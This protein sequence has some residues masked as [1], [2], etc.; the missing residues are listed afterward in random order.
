MSVKL[1]KIINIGFLSLLGIIVVL[2]L[3]WMVLTSFKLESEAKSMIPT[4]FPQN[5]TLI[6]YKTL[7]ID[8]KFGQYFFSTMVIVVL[9]FFGILI[10]SLAGFA[11]A[12][13]KFKGSNLFF[14]LILVTM[15]IPSQVTMIPVYLMLN[16]VS[17]TNTYI[18]IALPG[19]VSGFS[20]FMYKSFMSTIPNELMEAARLDGTSEFQIFYKIALPIIKPALAIQ[21]IFTFIGSWNSFMWP[22]ILSNSEKFYTLSVALNLL[23]GQYNAKYGIQMAGATLMIIPVIIVFIIFQKNIIEGNTLSGIK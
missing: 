19:L 15:M 23:K 6:H 13:Y 22:L 21:I 3:V 12:K 1:K 14:Y 17:L 5:P 9:S 8:L 7:F 10:N 4:L 18:G 20:I 2:P 11:F 16:G